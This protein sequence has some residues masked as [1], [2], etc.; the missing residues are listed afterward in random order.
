MLEAAF[1]ISIAI[2][3]ILFSQVR[4]LV[5]QQPKR[6]RNGRFTKRK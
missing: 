3:V 6:D 5:R 1:G 4:F 2:N